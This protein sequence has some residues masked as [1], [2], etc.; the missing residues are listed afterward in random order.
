MA[1]RVELQGL[2]PSLLDRLTDEDPKSN[3]EPTERS[4]ISLSDWRASVLR[5][6]AWLL[7]TTSLGQLQ[8]LERMPEVKRSVINYG[9]AP[10]TGRIATTA[11]ARELEMALRQAIIDFEP[12]ILKE[13]V[14]VRV[15][16]PEE[17]PSRHAILFEIEGD[18]FADPLPLHL[19][20]RTEIDL[21]S[22]DATVSDDTG[23]RVF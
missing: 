15:V 18:L 17:T 2:Q 22:G 11:Q 14:R 6:L 1:R 4:G 12:R 13:S 16:P 9:I 8:P 23:K 19:A 5:D 3:R 7:N 20:L 10:V 21:D